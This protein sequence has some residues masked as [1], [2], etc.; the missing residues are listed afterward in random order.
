[1]NGAEDWREQAKI[2]VKAVKASREYP[3]RRKLLIDKAFEIA[4]ILIKDDD[5]LVRK[6]YGCLFK[7]VSKTQPESVCDYVTTNVGR[8][9]RV[10]F[11]YAIEKLPDEIREKAMAK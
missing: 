9:P 8:M 11:R 4:D 10:A 2:D 6:G 3:V 5:D 7:E 1:M